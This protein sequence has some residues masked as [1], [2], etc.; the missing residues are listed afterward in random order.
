ML[1]SLSGNTKKQYNVTYKLWWQFCLDRNISNFESTVATVISFLT[2]EF[3][4]GASYGTLN[5]HSKPKYNYSWDPQLVLN[6]ISSWFPN[7]NI[8]LEQLTKKLVILLALCTAQRVQTLSLINL[9]NIYFSDSGAKIFIT[10]LIKTSAPGR[11]QPLL[12]LPYFK[13]NISICPATALSDYIYVTKHLRNKEDNRLILTFK[14]PNKPATTQTIS[15]WI[16]NVL[17]ESGVNISIFSAHSTRHASTS[18]ACASGVCVDNIRKT[19]GWTKHSESFARFYKL[20][21]INENEFA[22]SILQE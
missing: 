17:S 18:T 21:V 15:R 10:D 4:K 22:E 13:E 11:D 3:N 16:K 19:A 9:N 20:N 5:S 6:H 12:I 7:R 1:A 2:N 14:K 8:N